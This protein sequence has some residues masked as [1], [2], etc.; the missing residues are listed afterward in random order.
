MTIQASNFPTV[1]PALTLDLTRSQYLDPRITFA[2]ASIGTFVDSRGILQTAPVNVARF[3]HN[4]TTGESLGLL[5]EEARTNLLQRS[6][7]FETTWA[8]TSVSGFGVGSAVNVETAPNGTLTADLIAVANGISSGTGFVLQDIT[9]AATSTTYTVTTFAKAQDWNAV[10]LHAHDVATNNNR[11]TV[12]FSLATGVITTAAAAFGTFSAAS[13]ITATPFINGWFR[14]NLTFTSSTETGLRVRLVPN[15]S[16]TVTSDGTNGIYLWGAQLEA[17]AFPSSYILNV[18]TPLGVT[19]SADVASITGTNFSSW[20]NQTEG[21]VFND[22]VSIHSATQ[23]LVNIGATAANTGSS[24]IAIASNLASSQKRVRV[25][26]AASVD[27]ASLALGASSSGSRTR[28]AAAIK[29]DD[30][31]ASLDGGTALTDATGTVPT[32]ALMEIGSAPSGVNLGTQLHRRITYWPQ[33]LPNST[34]QPLTS[35]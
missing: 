31:A 27:Q 32:V 16:T 4:P 12:T 35:S 11:A 2:R 17:G 15:N 29:V 13:A 19:R 8:R 33:R 5:V 34:L 10:T 24:S 23:V 18:N 3:D 26:D 9:K 1:M 21:T 22:C 7:E 30:F 25:R 6:E 14:V 20:Y 28:I